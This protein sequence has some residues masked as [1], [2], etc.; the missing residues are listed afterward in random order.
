MTRRVS[1]FTLADMVTFEQIV[2]HF[3]GTHESLASALGITREAVTMWKGSVPQSRAFQIE[4][5]SGG[6]FKADQIPTKTRA[7]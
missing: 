1:V 2:E 4:I 7:A 5:L 6:K 3:G